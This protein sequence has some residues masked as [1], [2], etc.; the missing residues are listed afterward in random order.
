MFSVKL[1]AAILI[2]TVLAVCADDSSRLI[3]HQSPAYQIYNFD[4]TLKLSD[5]K[6]LLLAINGFSVDKEIKWTGLKSTK[7]TATPRVNILFLTESS[8]LEENKSEN[9]VEIEQDSSINFDYLQRYFNS[10]N[11][12][13]FVKFDSIPTKESLKVSFINY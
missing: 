3:V 10:E 8:L 5:L 2:A 12:G 6:S 7:P 4:T 11:N 9:T 13:I 1:L